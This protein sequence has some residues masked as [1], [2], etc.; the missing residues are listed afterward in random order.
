[1]VGAVEEGA[2]KVTLAAGAGA[3]AGATLACGGCGK[4][5]APGWPQ[6]AKVMSALHA[7]TI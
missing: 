5:S 1:M 4:Y 6:P 3:I 2:G 7:A